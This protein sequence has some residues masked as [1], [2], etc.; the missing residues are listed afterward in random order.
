MLN[1]YT[2]SPTSYALSVLTKA[3]ILEDGETP[4]EMF[5]RVVYTLFS[6][7]TKLNEDPKRTEFFKNRFAQYLAEK[8]FTPG[9]PTLNNAGRTKYK[10][11]AL[12]SCAIIPVDLRKKRASERK[13]IAYYSQNMGSGFDLTSYDDPVSLL[14]WLNDLAA[15]ET[16]TGKYDRYIGNMAN[17]HVSHPRVQEFITAKQKRYLAHFNLSVDVDDEFMHAAS[18]DV[19]YVLSNGKRIHAL[20]LLNEIAQ[21]VWLNGDPNIINLKKMNQDNPLE[22]SLPYTTTPP[23]SEMGMARG[24]TCQFGYI[25]LAYFVTPTGIDYSKLQDAVRTLTRALDNAIDVGLDKFPDP[26]SSR[27]ARYKRKIGIAISGVADLL[28]YYDMPYES[29]AARDFI[30]DLLAFVNYQ[31]KIM[32]I[33]L[34]EKRGPCEAMKDRKNNK[35]Y[36]NYL[37][38]RFHS[39]TKMIKAL[40]W[41]KLDERIKDTGL[42]RN[43]C[44]T[45]IPPAARVSILMNCSSGIEPFFG[46]P[47]DRKNMPESMLRFV[48][49]HA[50]GSTHAHQIVKHACE[51]GTFQAALLKNK[52]CLKTAKEI[53]YEKHLLMVGQLVG[54]GGMCDETASKTVNLP[55]SATPDDIVRVYLLAHKL[56]LKNIAVYRD[57]SIEEQPQKL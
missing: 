57:G 33:E 48:K 23:C 49:R 24:E 3:R 46:I 54:N 41:K 40:D 53:S 6:I 45:A 56:G 12:S 27:I 35:Y 43:I 25:N 36:K 34:A 30:R 38:K 8:A 31:S 5:N 16:A 15:R 28:L 2:Y 26:L 1:K 52:E 32:S 20:R 7:E 42:L 13:I 50:N 37:Q 29:Q 18:N 9:T 17:L 47:K 22:K 19:D 55:H 21:A 11:A 14:Y 4:Q 51:T 10:N 39:D 44:T